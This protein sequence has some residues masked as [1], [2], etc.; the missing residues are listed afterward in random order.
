MFFTKNYRIISTLIVSASLGCS[1]DT[2]RLLL[3]QSRILTNENQYKAAQ[4]LLN[5]IITDYPNS[6]EA[7]KAKA[8]LFFVTKRLDKDFDNRML[9]T[10]RSMIRIVIA[11]ERYRTDKKKLPSTLNELYPQYLSTLPLDGWGHP[12]FYTLNSKSEEFPYRV[13]SMG[14]ES[15][16][17][18]FNLLHPSL[19]SQTINLNKKP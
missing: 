7:T 10:R 19:T 8:E 11:I 5:Q 12:F 1:S 4:V 15:K 9:E 3:D 13:F 17:I 2:P 18:P 16:P 14:S 6:D